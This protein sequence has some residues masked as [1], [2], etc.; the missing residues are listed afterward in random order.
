MNKCLRYIVTNLGF[1]QRPE[2]VC[3]RSSEQALDVA[4]WGNMSA[5]VPDVQYPSLS[6]TG[7]CGCCKAATACVSVCAHPC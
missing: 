6:A 5:G 3:V 7:T 1:Q 4:Y 2:R